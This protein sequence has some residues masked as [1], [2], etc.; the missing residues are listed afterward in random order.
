M[1]LPYG[2]NSP[3]KG[4]PRRLAGLLRGISGGHFAE[5]GAE[6]FQ[7]DGAGVA[8]LFEG[9]EEGAEV[10]RMPSPG[11]ASSESFC[12]ATGRLGASLMWTQG[13]RIAGEGGQAVEGLAAGVDVVGVH[14]QAGVWA[15]GIGELEHL[16]GGEDE[17]VGVAAAVVVGADELQGQAQAGIREALGG[18]FEALDV[19]GPVVDERERGGGHDPGA[20]SRS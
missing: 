11:R 15:D 8:G 1:A 5:G 2:A 12:L 20:R 6:D 13:M 7:G 9:G 18:G 16:A 19:E 10:E 3:A 4:F 17:L 14:Q